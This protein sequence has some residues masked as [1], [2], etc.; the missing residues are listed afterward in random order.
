MN[1]VDRRTRRHDPRFA[2]KAPIRLLEIADGEPQAAGRATL[3]FRLSWS[4]PEQLE[5]LRDARRAMIREEWTRGLE[6]GEPS[7][8][9]A[10]FS[11]F[12]V[13]WEP[14]LGEK[15][16]CREKV[17]TLVRRANLLIEGARAAS[18]QAEYA[19]MKGSPIM[20]YAPVLVFVALVLSTGAQGQQP[21]SQQPPARQPQA[22]HPGGTQPQ[23]Q[24]PLEIY[25][26][27]LVPTG[28][29]FAM[30]KPVLEGDVYV[31]KVWP[32]QSTVRLP[33]SKVK[34]IALRTKEIQNQVVY[35]IDLA[36]TG[37]MYARDNPTL[38]GTTYT[39][40]RWSGG[41][42]MSVKQA[43]VKKVTRLSGLEALRTYLQLFGA[44]PIANLAMEGSATGPVP[45]AAQ[46]S[47]G[48]PGQPTNW[49]YMGV[50][51]VTDAWAPPAAVQSAPGDVP[52][53]PEPHN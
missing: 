33:K 41:T 24:Q 30:T 6:E 4:D 17:A 42:L 11:A 22:Q 32:D 50:P 23:A 18:L 40:H 16:R 35:Q 20:R 47:A 14:P 5:A 26:I 44:K 34:N 48:A 28:S 13:L 21:K 53:A 27:D 7:L 25:Q 1:V 19:R 43:D 12:A 31:F 29:G 10:V 9:E 8:S 46:G 39:F 3:C 49:L 45:A 37:Q 36:P 51:G 15:A 2:P 38:Q 52:K